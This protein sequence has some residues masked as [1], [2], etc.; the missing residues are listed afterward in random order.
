MEYIPGLCVRKWKTCSAYR[1]LPNN[2]DDD[3]I[4]VTVE[5]MHGI[6]GVIWGDVCGFFTI[7]GTL[8]IILGKNA[9]IHTKYDD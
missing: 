1:L 7:S 9:F 4:S 6:L 2:G 5:E 8:D 3:V